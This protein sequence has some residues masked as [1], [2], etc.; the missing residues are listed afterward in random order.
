MKNKIKA[1]LSKIKFCLGLSPKI[2]KKKSLKNYIPNGCK[3]VCLISADFEMAW[4]S[5]YSKSTKTPL[6]KAI[7]DGL[8][9]RENV[10]KIL[11]LCDIYKIPI[12]WATV[13]HLFL[14]ECKTG[15]GK[16]HSDIPRLGYFENQ[17]WKFDKGDWFDYDPCTNYI[18]DPAWYAPDLI[19]DIL[20][21][22]TKHEIGCHTFSH[23]DCRDEVGDEVVFCKEIEKCFSLAKAKNIRLTSFVHPGHTIGHLD[24]L[25]NYGFTSIR[26]DYGDALMEPKQ[27]DNGLWEFRNSAIID[28]RRG[29]S[30]KYHIKR[31]KKIIDRAIKYN[32]LCVL[33]FHPSFDPI[34]VTEIM[35][36]L[37]GY[38]NSKREDILIGTHKDYANWLLKNN[39][40]KE[41][42]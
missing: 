29:W 20:S 33:W 38:L 42:S 2:Y 19:D 12:T 8:V 6:K 23:I 10:P 24:Q 28:Y 16:K 1:N 27:H 14:E 9:T 35:P 17:F 4:A 31:Y 13:G 3:A 26:T 30:V 37:F 7:N 41:K 36:E 25:V 39:T 34:V 32:K 18:K 11:D 21:R 5:R 40:L 22:K 15:N